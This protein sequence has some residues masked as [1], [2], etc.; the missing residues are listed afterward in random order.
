MRKL[1]GISLVL[2]GVVIKLITGESCYENDICT[3]ASNG[4][5]GVGSIASSCPDFKKL[6]YDERSPCG[7]SEDDQTIPIICCPTKTPQPSITAAV[8]NPNPNRLSSETDAPITTT[9]TATASGSIATKKCKSFPERSDE[10]IFDLDDR[11][12][13]GNDSLI[14]E[15]PHFAMLGYRNIESL[16]ITFDCGGALISENFV[17]TAAHCCKP[18]RI[19]EVVRFGRVRW[20]TAL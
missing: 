10:V 17:L 6:S 1:S 15:F 14:A 8:I 19:P 3:L 13:G 12:I 20:R 18:S 2:L 16:Q 4:K 9:T 7:W 11:V 5:N